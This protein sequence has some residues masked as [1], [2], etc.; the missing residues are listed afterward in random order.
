MSADGLPDRVWEPPRLARALVAVVTLAAVVFLLGRLGVR[1]VVPTAIVGAG[2]GAAG[3]WL[4]A[5]DR[6]R[7]AAVALGTLL[8]VPVGVAVGATVLQTALAETG[9][10]LATRTLEQLTLAVVRL[11]LALLVV[12]ACTVALFG[13]FAT[14]RTLEPENVSRGF[15]TVAKL[16]IPPT[17]YVLV[18]GG[19]AVLSSPAVPPTIDL[20]RLLTTGVD[21][22]ATILLSPP[23]PSAAATGVEGLAAEVA[24]A[25]F[26]VLALGGLFGVRSLLARLPVAELLASVGEA[27]DDRAR[28]V[29]GTLVSTLSTVGLLALIP[30]ALV[31]VADIV[32]SPAV[33]VSTLGPTPARLLFDVVST[34]L[35]RW[36]AV[37][38]MVGAVATA[39]LLAQLRRLVRQSTAETVI[40]L[41]PWL[42]GVGALAATLVVAPGL[43]SSL[44][45]RI[46]GRL[47]Q[48]SGQFEQIA[49]GVVEFYGPG[50]LLV[51]LFVATLFVTLSLFAGLSLLLRLG[52]LTRAQPGSALAGAGLF[53]AAGLAAGRSLSLGVVAVVVAAALLASD[54]GR[55]GQTLGTELGRYA[56]TTGVQTVRAGFLTVTGVVAL[57]A[58]LAVQRFALD[59][60]VTNLPAALPLVGAVGCCVALVLVLWR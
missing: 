51:T 18:V 37:G 24:V 4:L 13:S 33:F 5:R 14:G 44:I 2:C 48:F 6:Y 42:A 40:P 53:V 55:D 16:T 54:L 31:V 29:V 38:A 43:V 9:N 49:A 34:S 46:A 39:L 20:V 59:G 57:A 10:L 12:A 25:T 36:L 35:L 41:L 60:F 26:A 23:S 47:G 28:E 58:A 11:A 30:V 15:W 50:T 7:P 8:F 1:Q 19:L 27:D 52:L 32:V 45:A 22:L 3:L 17:A 21:A 56:D